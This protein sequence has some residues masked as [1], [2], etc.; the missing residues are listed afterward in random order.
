MTQIDLQF[1]DEVVRRCGRSPQSLVPALQA[2]QEHYGFVPREAMQRLCDLTDIAPAAVEGVVS[3]YDG[4]RRSRAGKHTIS[5]CHGT[6]CHVKGAT[7]VYDAFRRVL[8]LDG[9]NDTDAAGRFT[10]RKVACLGCCTLAPAVQIDQVTYGHLTPQSVA[11]VLADF[12]RLG[13]LSPSRQAIAMSS[14]QYQ[15]QVLIGLG[16]CCVARGSERVRRALERAIVRTG[17][18][19]QVKSIGCVGMCHQTP[20]LEVRTP[21][22]GHLYAK[23]QADDVEA[24][25]VRHF[26]RRGLVRT[27]LGGLSDVLGRAVQG[28]LLNAPGVRRLG[29]DPREPVVSAFLG[30]QRQIATELRGQIDP[31]DLDEYL[32][33]G[34]FAALAKARELGPP[35]V[36]EEITRSGLAGRGGAGFPTGVKWAAV[37]SQA[38]A[39][40]YAICNGDE[41]DPGAIM[42]RMLL[43]SYHYRVIEGLAVAALATGAGE[44]I[45]YI[46][47]EY[48]LAV[49]RVEA[50]LE[51][52]RTRGLLGDL[53][54]S[55]FRGAGAFVCGEETALIASIQGDRG[56][57]RLRPPYPS[58]QGLCGRPTLVN[59]VETLAMVPWILRCGGQAYAAIG[60][61]CT[62][63]TK[64]FALAGKVSRG[65]LVEVP[66]GTSVEAIVQHIG[67]GA[68]QRAVKA[69]QIGGPS[70]GCLSREHFAV[71]IDYHE[72]K[73]HGSIMGSGGLVVLDED[74]CMVDIARYFLQF[75]QG[76][77]CGRCTFCRIGTRRMLDILD[78]LCE[79]RGRP[80]DLER[81]EQL[82]HSVRS[83]SL[84][85]LGRTA[86][87]PVVS[88][89]AQFRG[90]YEAHLEGRCPAGRCTALIRYAITDRCIG[91][92]I[93]S[94]HCPVGAIAAR[95]Y[96][97]HEVD[98]A[99][100]TRCGSCKTACPATAIEVAQVR[101]AQTMNGEGLSAQAPLA[102]ALVQVPPSSGASAELGGAKQDRRAGAVDNLGEGRPS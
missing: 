56:M 78:A 70:G 24:I 29:L 22:G 69:V 62:K 68:G 51:T 60:T 30:P 72:L 55:V 85:G 83:G 12:E 31:L 6:A 90:E 98:D 79:G 65:G 7:A 92:T 54:M 100:C 19:V 101:D 35:G 91:C 36:I 2:I 33:A 73:R 3:F 84:C 50:A 44:A 21:R 40:K 42:D 53:Q 67:G 89:L 75:T 16:S 95:P 18:R 94:Q 17:A 64:V 39:T 27:L 96:H 71:G 80:G 82:A 43:E 37:A 61:G 8:K 46:R 13:R 102:Q 38:A 14:G 5:V 74:D 76:Q 1:V 97:R 32:A 48:P 86:P 25:I 47:G 26:G 66:M 77:S 15:G 88:T 58:Q 59:N 28:D 23:V 63:G 45:F 9:D 57:P 49:Q 81:L 10:L 34:G 87:N 4:F 93:C 11:G 41:G 99:L 20:L 52:C